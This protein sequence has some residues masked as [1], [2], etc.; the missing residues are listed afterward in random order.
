QAPVSYQ[1]RAGGTNLP[2]AA[3]AKSI[4]TV[5]NVSVA[6]NNGQVYRCVVSNASG[7]VTSAPATLTVT[8][9]TVA[10]TLVSA[11]NSG[12]SNVIVRFSEAVEPASAANRTNYSTTPGIRVLSAVL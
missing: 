2:G 11:G 6:L 8:P 10:P 7:S 12:L 4:Y 3:A 5:S 9:D 1:W